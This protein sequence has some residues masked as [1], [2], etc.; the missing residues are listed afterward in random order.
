L[1]LLALPLGQCGP[2]STCASGSQHHSRH[3][4][5]KA[6]VALPPPPL[7][8]N[9]ARLQMAPQK[10]NQRE[11]SRTVQGLEAHLLLLALPLSWQTHPSTHVRL[12]LKSLY[13]PAMTHLV[14]YNTLHTPHG[15]WQNQHQDTTGVHGPRPNY[16][17]YPPSC[18]LGCGY[19]ASYCKAWRHTCW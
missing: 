5:T 13:Q 14:L 18:K 9:W 1:L 11:F 12:G 3:I 4:Y 2:V 7:A 17:R 15:M 10:G 16:G 8:A 19:S 6:E